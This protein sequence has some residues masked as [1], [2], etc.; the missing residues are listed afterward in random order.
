MLLYQLGTDQLEIFFGT[1]RTITHSDNCDYLELTERCKMAFQI[2][3]V[4]SKNPN[5]RKE[6]RISSK[7]TEDHSSVKS[8]C[9]DLKTENLRLVALWSFGRRKAELTLANFG[10]DSLH[11]ETS[12]PEI[13]MMCPFGSK[14]IDDSEISEEN[15][16]NCPLND[17]YEEEYSRNLQDLINT[18]SNIE[19]H[20]MYVSINGAYVHKAN[21]V[22]SIVNNKSKTSK[23]RVIR[24][25]S[26][27][28]NVADDNLFEMDDSDSFL[29]LNDTVLGNDM[30]ILAFSFSY[31]YSIF[32]FYKY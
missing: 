5:L 18:S 22:N 32:V 14:L 12:D 4:Y 19:K 24:V 16:L 26:K 10:F 29:R 3:K 9:G 21:A 28:I 27:T 15:P 1:I 25:Q 2:E 6:S 13:T 17:Y 30:Y 7:T 23:D 20:S 11:F 8:W 31:T